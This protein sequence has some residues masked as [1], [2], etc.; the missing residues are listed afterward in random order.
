MIDQ[1]IY[2]IFNAFGIPAEVTDCVP[3]GHGH[4][5]D[6]YLLRTAGTDSPDYILQRKN[7]MIFRDVPG[8]LSNILKATGHIRGKLISQGETETDRKVMR[9][10]PARDGN[11]FT[12]DDQGN[13]WTLFL[14]VR[15]SHGIEEVT[16]TE[17]AYSAGKAF[18][19][20]QLQLSDLDGSGLIET[21]PDFHN[22]LFRFRQFEEALRSD[23]AG[24]CREMQDVTARLM[25]R[26]DEMLKLQLWLDNGELPLRITHNDTKI[27]N[28]LFDSNDGILCI[29][30]LDTVMPGS[31]LFDF[32][33]AIRTLGDSAPEDE[34]DLTKISFRSDYFNAFTEGYLSESRDFLTGK[35]KE[36][37]VFACRYMVW[38][39]AI[40]FLTDYLNGDI[41]YKTAY[42]GHNKVRTLSQLRYLEVLE[43]QEEKME[44]CVR[45]FL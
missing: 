15:D 33:D 1:K 26:K 20:F 39:Q 36:N 19:Q 31:I 44:E 13:Y 30:D 28:I 25:D 6:T 7:H 45:S 24:R 17:Q 16:N 38:E 2:S 9:Y 4:I 23:P 10:Y 21:I 41:Y 43:E 35:E 27:N 22:G 12:R 3:F 5:N 14:F 42:P 34:P 40:R 18:G 8:M 29:I 37:L 11:Y 32:G